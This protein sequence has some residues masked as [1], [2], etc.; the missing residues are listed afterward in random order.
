[1]GLWDN[2]DFSMPLSGGLGGTQRTSNMD[3]SMPLS[4]GLGGTQSSFADA[5][6]Y[7]D[8]RTG[9][10]TVPPNMPP[11]GIPG[12]WGMNATP[13]YYGGGGGGLSGGYGMGGGGGG[14][15][16]AAAAQASAARAEAL[17]Q[18][19][20]A[21][22]QYFGSP[23]YKGMTSALE[24]QVSGKEAPF[25]Q[26]VQDVQFARSADQIAAAQDAA[27]QR[28]YG[29][30]GASGTGFSLTGGLGNRM[31]A[32]EGQGALQRQ[33][34][35]ADIQSN[36]AL[37]NYNARQR[38]IGLGSSV[39]ASAYGV[40]NPL[41][42]QATAAK[43]GTEWGAGLTGGTAPQMNRQRPTLMGAGRNYV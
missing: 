37:Q 13:G 14:V 33:G 17:G 36:A 8:P 1:M 16:P 26:S 35:L 38:A 42:Q 9:R 21:R 11:M 5:G 29:R 19:Q 32:I 25:S 43:F 22:S 7:V 28:A 15:D 40:T 18:L 39:M 41:L 31:A 30:A 10:L 27:R 20:T 12:S 2:M 34:S 23:L 6:A 4:G 3:F 24:G